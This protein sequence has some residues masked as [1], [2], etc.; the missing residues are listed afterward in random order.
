MKH[1][2]TLIL[3]VALSTHLCAQSAIS[4]KKNLPLKVLLAKAKK[5][6]KILFIDAYTTWCGPC[7]MMDRDVFSDREVGAFYNEH[8]INAKIDMEKGEGP[9]ISQ[10]YRVRGYPSFLFLDSDGE[11]VHRGIGYI[12]KTKFLNL[13]IKA[14]GSNS[15]KAL[16]DQYESRKNDPAFLY[17]YASTLVSLG[18]T[19]RADKVVEAYLQIKDD[20]SDKS[21]MELIMGS[22]GSLGGKRMSYMIKHADRFAEMIGSSQFINTAQ[23]KFVLT[24]MQKMGR[25]ALPSL[26]A[27][28]ELYNEYAGPLQDQLSRHFAVI[29]AEKTRDK[30]AHAKAAVDYY[31]EYPSDNSNELNSV[32][33]SFYENVKDQDQLLEAIEWAKRSVEIEKGYPNLDT[34]AWLYHKTG[35]IEMAKKTAKEAIALAKATG[36]NYSETAKMLN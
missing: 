33:W 36:Q 2:I 26:Q 34:L 15:I 22:P 24:Q 5:E 35:Q 16:G 20:W 12:E 6:N 11:I 14:T 21:S 25:R 31:N 13:G 32:A 8:F 19:D 9:E 10:K 4:F 17:Q 7:K 27:M 1:I 29:H 23:N 28:E 3:L 18:E 30:V